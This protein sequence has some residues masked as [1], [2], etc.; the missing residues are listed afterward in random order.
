MHE[1]SVFQIRNATDT[2]IV[3]LVDDLWQLAA[4][5]R[6]AQAAGKN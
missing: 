1:L 4:V 2:C 6:K 3:L 5:H